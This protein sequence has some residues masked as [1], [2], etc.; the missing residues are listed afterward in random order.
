MD[1]VHPS[2]SG[3]GQRLHRDDVEHEQNG[4]PR[5]PPDAAHAA[6]AGVASRRRLC[7]RRRFVGAVPFG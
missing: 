3:H 5:W 7:T 2:G 6:A 1:V 4:R